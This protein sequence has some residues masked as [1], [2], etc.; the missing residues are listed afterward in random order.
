M[1]LGLFHGVIAQ[2]GVATAPYGVYSRDESIDFHQYLRDVG[3]L[4]SCHG[5]GPAGLQG[6]I[7]CLRR[8][9]QTDIIAKRGN[10]S[11]SSRTSSSY[12]CLSPPPIIS[13]QSRLRV[14]TCLVSVYHDARCTQ[15]TSPSEEM[16]AQQH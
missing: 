5:R 12:I 16:Y 7:A 10:V 13:L 15:N 4:F 2:S 8:V 6:V 11:V 3:H 9:P 1:S 14:E